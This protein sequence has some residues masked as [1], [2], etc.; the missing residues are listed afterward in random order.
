MINMSKASS[1]ILLL[2][3]ATNK[4]EQQSLRD[5]FKVT[6]IMYLVP[7]VFTKSV[8]RKLTRTGMGS[9]PMKNTGVWSRDPE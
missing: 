6:V 4:R 3:K 8:F 9:C 7:A 1:S 2:Q 5:A